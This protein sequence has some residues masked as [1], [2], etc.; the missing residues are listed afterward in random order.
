MLRPFVIVDVRHDEKHG[1]CQRTSLCARYYSIF[2]LHLCRL[3]CFLFARCSVIDGDIRR[4]S[5]LPPQPAPPPIATAARAWSRPAQAGETTDIVVEVRSRLR[6]AL[7]AAVRSR[8]LSHTALVPRRGATP[9]RQCL[10]AC[11]R[12]EVTK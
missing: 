7:S 1:D 6:E 10:C 8:S 2:T 5:E 4:H 11:A 9:A 12:V 3:P